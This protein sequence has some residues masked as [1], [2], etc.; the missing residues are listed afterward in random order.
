MICRFSKG[1]FLALNFIRCTKLEF[2][3]LP[4]IEATRCLRVVVNYFI[5][6]FDY[7]IPILN[8]RSFLNTVFCY[9]ASAEKLFKHL[10]G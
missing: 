9:T 7:Y 6:I 10:T 2:F 1:G 4:P 5:F 8:K 3:T